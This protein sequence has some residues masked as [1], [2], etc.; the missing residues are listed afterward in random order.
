MTTKN[1]EAAK[2]GLMEMLTAQRTL[3]KEV[4]AVGLL[5]FLFLFVCG[6]L[7]VSANSLQDIGGS[8]VHAYQSTVDQLSDML[9]DASESQ[10]SVVASIIQSNIGVKPSMFQGSS[11]MPRRDGMRMGGEHSSS[12]QSFG[13]SEGDEK[14]DASV[15]ENSADA[16]S[17]VTVQL[18]L[19]PADI[20]T[21]QQFLNKAGFNISQSGDGSTGNE[22][23]SFGHKTEQAFRKF[24]QS[25]REH[26]GMNNG[27][28]GGGMGS[29][30]SMGSNNQGRPQGMPGRPQGMP[31]NTS[32]VN[33]NQS[34]GDLQQ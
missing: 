22:T 12:T 33:Q 25:L 15:G 11:T 19:S 28:M 32:G 21:I 10:G 9:L 26:R 4:E 14:N 30:T 20:K 8:Y 18:Q 1:T 5:A 27:E 23:T 24:L 16:S 6:P 17:T 34:G 29:S 31:V 2:G 13:R 7:S 3:W